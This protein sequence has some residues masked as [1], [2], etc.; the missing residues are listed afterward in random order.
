VEPQDFELLYQ[1]EEKYWWF[2]AM[3][4]ITDAIAERELERANSRIL[5]AGC[6]T[7]FNL[8]HYSRSRGREVYG[9]DLADAALQHVRLR[10]VSKIAKASVTDVPFKCEA[11]DLVFSFD[12][13]EMLPVEQHQIALT[14]M[15]RVLAPGGYVFIRVPALKLLWS[16]HDVE[17]PAL[18][19]FNRRE[20]EKRLIDAGFV[21]EWSSY[22]NGFLFPVVLAR[23]VLKYVGIGRGTDVKPLPKGLGWL[24]GIFR[25]VLA[26]E[27]GWFKA[28]RRL[29]FGVS[30]ICYA[31][32]PSHREAV[33]GN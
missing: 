13:L 24:D 7:G 17:L 4:Q 1:L 31:R 5:D 25:R 23:R 28:G 33:A 15:Y 29:P 3:R 21:V 9:I 10:G 30:L 20:L 2:V 19:R 11:F 16:S 12:V 22:A 18:H 26:A 6:G 14:E 32:K 8:A 27:A